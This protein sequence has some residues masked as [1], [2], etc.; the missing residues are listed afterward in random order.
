MS[1][2]VLRALSLSIQTSTRT[3]CNMGCCYCISRITPGN[4]KCKDEDLEYC[5]SHRLKVGLRFAQ[6]LGAT[7]AILTGKADPLQEGVEYLT[8][9]VQQSSEH[10]PLVDIHTNGKELQPGGKYENQLGLLAEAGLTMTTFSIAS[11]D[12]QMN[13][14]LM[15]KG[16]NPDFL[17]AEALKHQLMVRC[18]LVVN[19]QGAANNNDVLDY[20]MEAGRRGAHSVVVRE[21]WCPETYG[22]INSRVF[23]WNKANFVAIGSLEH[24]FQINAELRGINV[25]RLPDLPWG[26]KVFG[27]GG[28]NF[29]GDPAHEV[30]VTFAICD[31]PTEGGVLKSVVHLPNGHGYPSWDGRGGILY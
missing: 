19:R 22:Q 7:H 24:N 13:Q 20:I 9:L 27:V 3:R 4:T 26:T 14:R 5:L 1:D 30:N 8:G 23:D 17:I 11:F 31:Q 28:G 10:L 15:G 2:G 6:H 12:R 29:D 16:Q 25:R 21:V 18:S